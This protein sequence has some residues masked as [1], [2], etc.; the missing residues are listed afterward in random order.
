MILLNI[1]IVFLFFFGALNAGILKMPGIKLVIK[2]YN[3]DI[4][5]PKIVSL[6]K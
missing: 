2:G 3:K 6:N 4:I 5:N 1:Y